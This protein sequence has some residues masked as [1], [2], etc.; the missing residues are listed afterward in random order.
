MPR[1]YLTVGSLMVIAADENRVCRKKKEKRTQTRRCEDVKRGHL[2]TVII[3]TN[4]SCSAVIYFETLLAMRSG[5]VD[6]N[7]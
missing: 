7:W 2:H 3:N 6:V 5:A 1:F 4:P